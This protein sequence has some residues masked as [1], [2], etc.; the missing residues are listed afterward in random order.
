MSTAN[1]RV[2]ALVLKAVTAKVNVAMAIEAAI[3]G[4]LPYGKCDFRTVDKSLQRLRKAG[5]IIF[6]KGVWTLVPPEIVLP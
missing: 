6:T 2:D 3:V 5:K 1:D 4:D